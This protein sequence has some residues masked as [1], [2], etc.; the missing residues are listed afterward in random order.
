M[1]LGGERWGVERVYCESLTRE[2]K[3][4]FCETKKCDMN[5]FTEANVRD[6]AKSETNDQ[7]FSVAM[8]WLSLEASTVAQQ[9]SMIQ[10]HTSPAGKRLAHTGVEVLNGR[11]K[12]LPISISPVCLHHWSCPSELPLSTSRT[13]KCDWWWHPAHHSNYILHMPGSS[14]PST[15]CC[16]T[17]NGKL[18]L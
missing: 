8:A 3:I 18:E 2:N 1:L 9:S 17:S 16:L 5:I 6:I 13:I 15:C 10:N 4:G 12:Q 11:L 7:M 14:V